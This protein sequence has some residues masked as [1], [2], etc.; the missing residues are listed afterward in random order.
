MLAWLEPWAS[1]AIWA[2]W[3]IWDVFGARDGVVSPV[4]GEQRRAVDRSAGAAP[5]LNELGVG[6][7]THDTLPTYAGYTPARYKVRFRIPDTWAHVGLLM[8]PDDRTPEA[9]G[10]RRDGKR[11]WYFPAIPGTVGET[12]ADA[13]EMRI[14]YAPFPHICQTCREC[15]KENRGQACP[16]H[17]WQLSILERLVFTVGR[18]LRLWAERLV[19]AREACGENALARAA[20]RN[21]LLHTIGAFHGTRR[22]ITRM[23]R[24]ADVPLRTPARTV[25]SPEGDE[26]HLWDEVGLAPKFPDYARPEWSAQVW[27]RTRARLLLHQDYDTKQFVGALTLPVAQIVAFRL[28]ALYLTCDPGWLDSGRPGTLRVK[29]VLAGPVPWPQDEDDLAAAQV[30]LAPLEGGNGK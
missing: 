10:P 30:Q 14:A 16:K 3:A 11:H 18:P 9:G 17:G 2:I 22:P 20:V 8:V 26:L 15:Y 13:A 5:A 21:L 29:G 28:D 19:A 4:A 27:A 7:A 1:W 12:W 24:L 25:L 6:P 23:A